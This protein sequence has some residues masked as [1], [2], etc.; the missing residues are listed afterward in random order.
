MVTVFDVWREALPK[1]TGLVGGRAGLD[2]AVEWTIA[3]RNRPPALEAVRAGA[4]AFIPVGGIRLLDERL[5][6]AAVIGDLARDGGV[7]AAVVGEVGPHAIAASERMTVPLF[8]LQGG[9]DIVDAHLAAA[10]FILDRR[11]SLH[12]LELRVHN[13]LVGLA[14]TGAGTAA[15]VDCL[16][17]ITGHAALLQTPDG[18]I[19]HASPRALRDD[20]LAS[21]AVDLTAAPMWAAGAVAAVAD[22]P[23]RAFALAAAGVVQLAAPIPGRGGFAGV[24]SVVGGDVD[25][26]GLARVAVARAASACAIDLDRQRAVLDARDDLEAQLLDALLGDGASDA[27]LRSQADRLDVDL[28]QAAVALVARPD[29]SHTVSTAADRAKRLARAQAWIRRSAPGALAAVR[30]EGLVAVVPLPAAAGSEEARRL[31]AELRQRCADELGGIPVSVGVGRPKQ[32][33]EGV[34]GSHREAEQALTLG[35][36]LFGGDRTTDFG[37][38]GVHRLLSALAARPELREFFDDQVGAVAE[39]DRRTGGRLMETLDAYF[40][41]HGSPTEMAELLHVHRNTVVHRLRR[42]EDVGRLRLDDPS[43]RL[44]LHLCLKVGDVLAAHPG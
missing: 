4:M 1:G 21:P 19:R 10:R 16:D 43:T 15:I 30:P 20:T 17:E 33:V 39:H 7:A 34:A 5:D 12:E 24:V 18:R 2:R 36:R 32:G 25:A 29:A 23:V 22:P 28:G 26:A 31:G 8:R 44:A 3:L 9:T 11:A 13:E 6:L 38:L 41:C 27:A 37:E 40:A 14:L 35:S 42:I